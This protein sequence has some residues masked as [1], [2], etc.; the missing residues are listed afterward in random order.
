[1]I[2]STYTARTKFHISGMGRRT[3]YH[4]HY[5]IPLLLY[6][7]M[8]PGAK[9][10]AAAAARLRKFPGRRFVLR[11]LLRLDGRLLRRTNGGIPQGRRH[12]GKLCKQA[13]HANDVSHRRSPAVSG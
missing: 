8:Y 2:G 6:F 12:A 4:A 11:I 13:I 10:Y 5:S 3:L 7:R 9:R 1:M